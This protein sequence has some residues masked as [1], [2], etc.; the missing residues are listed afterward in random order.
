MTEKYEL[1]PPL[2]TEE[3]EALQ[4]DIAVNGIRQPIFV[5]ENGDIL[6][7][8]HRYK[9]DPNVGR[10]VV[11]G[12]TEAEKIAFV[13]NANL[14]RRNLSPTQKKAARKK[15]QATAIL[16]KQEGKTQ[17]QIATLFG[18]T[19]QAVGNWLNINNTND[20]NA[21]IP[22][23][24][25]KIPKSE[26][27][28]V[29]EQAKDGIS[30]TQIAAN[31]GVTQPAVSAIINKV[32]KQFELLETAAAVDALEA[33]NIE[34]SITVSAGEWWA[35]GN[36]LLFCGDTSTDTFKD[37]IGEKAALAFADPPY[38]VNKAG[39]DSKFYWEHDYLIE[40]ANVV[41]V[42]PG[43]VSIFEFARITTMPYVWSLACL[44]ENGMTRGAVGFGNWIYVS[45]F[46]NDSVYA[47]SQDIIRVQIKTSE[48]D[49]KHESRKPSEL[50]IKL[51][52]NYTK[53]DQFVI[54][55]FLGSGTTLFACEEL[56]RVCIGGEI[57]P[58]Y[59]KEIIERWQVQTG[60]KAMRL[61]A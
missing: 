41:A 35:L 24:R 33:A 28:K 21:Y 44:I 8:H 47:Q 17:E 30:Q 45:L 43:I 57:N 40:K 29:Y 39:W 51:I 26:H 9:I 6:D 42:T 48:K 60:D 34:S 52:Q 31:Y 27:E 38:G 4:N 56:G 36:H 1:L 10:I 59:C 49:T 3:F 37:R 58:G 13:Y 15:M 12:K 2:S 11:S 53:E 61:L 5:D 46:T 50:L 25:V 16:L 7:G 32:T 23:S 14:T 54:D 18:V 55:P 20:C 22:D 19:Q